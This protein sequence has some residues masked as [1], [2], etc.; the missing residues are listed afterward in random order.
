MSTL[1]IGL[2]GAGRVAQ[3]HLKAC[4]ALGDR[5]KVLAV[6][7]ADGEKARATA[8]RAGALIAETDYRRLLSEDSVDAVIISLPHEF[9]REAVIE[10]ARAGKQILVE[11]PMALY[12]AEAEEMVRAAEDA[13]VTLMVGQSRRFS[14]AV[15]ALFGK[16]DEI[17]HILRIG[18]NFLVNF[19]QAP[20][21]WWSET[22]GD[23]IID[24]QG[25]HYLDLIVWLMGGLP[26]TVFAT[27]R[28]AN[29][30]YS[31]T[32]EG[33]ILAVYPGGVTASVHLSLNTRPELHELVVVGDRGSARIREWGIGRPFEFGLSLEV[34][35][36]RLMEGVQLPSNYTLQLEE[37][38]NAVASGRRPLASGREVLATVRLAEAATRSAATREVVRL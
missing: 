23:L 20:T 29:P 37:F 3:A 26:E 16:R 19:P 8:E 35:G 5:V 22:P 33:D 2:I 14:H 9:H 18:V 24:L 36:E 30:G 13:G 4:D 12:L 7:D 34:N 21:S 38:V 32:D 1:N 6:C 15:R 10:A 11:K 31:A 27:T 25:S 17:G 28:S